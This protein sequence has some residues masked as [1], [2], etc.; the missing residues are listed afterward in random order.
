MFLVNDED[1]KKTLNWLKINQAP[2][3]IV[4]EKWSLTSKHRL[5][6]L[7]KSSDKILSN[8]F[9]EWPLLKHPYGYKLIKHDFNQM[10]LT[11][12]CLTSE[13]W[14]EF[15]NIIKQNTQFMSKNDNFIDLIE[16]L[17]LDRSEG[18]VMHIILILCC[19]IYNVN[20]YLVMIIGYLI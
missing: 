3:E 20:Y 11:N 17:K 12:F 16:K 18:K 19:T 15:F 7:M 5:Q 4:L 2:W 14:N 1:I 13:K 6:V 9:E 10:Q 8:I